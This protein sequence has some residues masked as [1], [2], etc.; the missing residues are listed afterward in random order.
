M[1]IRINKLGVYCQM[2]EESLIQPPEELTEDQWWLILW[3]FI[4]DIPENEWSDFAHDLIYKNRFSLSHKVVEVIKAFSEKCTATFKK[5]QILYRARLYFQ[6]P[7][8]EFLAVLGCGVD[9]CYPKEHARLYE[10]INIHGCIISEYPPGTSPRG[11]LFPRRN[12][13]IAALSDEVYVI[14]A[15]RNSGA[16][17]TAGYCEK[18]GR[19]VYKTELLESSNRA[20]YI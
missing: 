4:T 18:Y 6:D 16:N 12:R 15:G 7:L 14:D 11:Y 2:S 1:S 13:L 5:G 19:G 20:L 9:I 10:E 3:A 8:Q 17:L